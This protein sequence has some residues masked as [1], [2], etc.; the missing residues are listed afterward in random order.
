M[1][2]REFGD[3][4]ALGVGEDGGESVEFAV[5]ANV[6]GD[7]DA[8]GLEAAVE[9][10]ELDTGDV[11]DGGVEEFARHGLAHG[12]LAALLPSRDEVITLID[13]LD[14]AGDLGGVVLEIAVHGDD[15]VVVDRG[16]P[17]GETSGLAEVATMAKTTD[18]GIARGEVG[19]HGPGAVS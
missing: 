11:A 9:V 14:E 2:H 7:L 6:L 3:A 19:D 5:E 16:E 15:E 18:M 1:V 12:I 4:E 10:V 13:R 8:V 17:G